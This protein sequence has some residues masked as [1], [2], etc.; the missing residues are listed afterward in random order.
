M[1][2]EVGS[3]YSDAYI[4]IYVARTAIYWDF[5][6]SHFAT[7]Y[8]KEHKLETDSR[9][10]GS[11]YFS[12]DGNKVAALLNCREALWIWDLV[13]GQTQKTPLKQNYCN[14]SPD[15]TKVTYQENL[16]FHL[17]DLATGQTWKVLEK[18]ADDVQADP[19]HVFSP[20]ST[21]MATIVRGSIS[22]W[23]TR[24]HPCCICKER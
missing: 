24:Q 22:I 20:E 14:I 21:R 6:A 17:W 10:Y 15:G 23:D 4:P 12:H 7:L 19:V 18:P 16:H 11:P 2:S 13:T 1:K 8:T 9:F 3:I 5:E